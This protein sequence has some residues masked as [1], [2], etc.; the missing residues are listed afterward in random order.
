LAT[1]EQPLFADLPKSE[2]SPRNARVA[3]TGEAVKLIPRLIEAFRWNNKSSVNELSEQIATTLET[4]YPGVSKQLRKV[5]QITPTLMPLPEKL[6]SFETARFGLDAVILPAEVKTQCQL[7]IEEHSKRAEL[8]AYQLDPRHRILLH[9][10]TGNGKTTLAEAIAYELGVPFL[11]VKYS[12]LVESHLGDTGRNLDK[13]N[14][15]ASTNPC[16][17]F[18]DEFDGIGIDRDGSQSSGSAGNEMQRVVNQLL[19]SLER[20]PSTC[21]YVAATNMPGH[22]DRALKR[23]FDLILEIPD[24]TPELI[25]D[26]ARR[27]LHPNLTAGVDLSAIADRIAGIGLPNFAEVAALCKR[28][29]RDLALHE[30][31]GIESLLK[32]AEEW[33][34]EQRP[35]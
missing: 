11:R 30:G 27:E 31:D 14:E 28:M 21:V 22:I 26:C 5:R 12:G 34:L 33:A 25:R 16:V 13:I 6:L 17:V 24:P 2:S 4:A 15:Y 19:I 3:A 1:I 8:A 7:F 32:K 18:I 29:R 20:I 9:G 10:P 23:R 35:R